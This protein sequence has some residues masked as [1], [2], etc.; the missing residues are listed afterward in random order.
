MHLVFYVTHKLDECLML[1]I[2]QWASIQDFFKV[3]INF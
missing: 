1:G 3:L 2:V